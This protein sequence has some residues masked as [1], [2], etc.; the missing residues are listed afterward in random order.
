MTNI[1]TEKLP[2]GDLSGLEKS[3]CFQGFTQGMLPIQNRRINDLD[4][5]TSDLASDLKKTQTEVSSFSDKVKPENLKKIITSLMPKD[6]ISKE[7]MKAH[8]LSSIN[9]MN[10]LLALT[11][12]Q[13][14][15]ANDCSLFIK[16]FGIEN[17]NI[18]KITS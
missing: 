6:C 12:C 9:Y 7:E 8:T 16:A 5:K 13:M 4:Q 11:I 3:S 1:N 18:Q 17:K 14:D 10:S 2:C 15:K